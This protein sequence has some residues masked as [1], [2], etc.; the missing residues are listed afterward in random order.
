ME[1]AMSKSVSH[2]QE[3]YEL[4]QVD[5]N[6]TNVANH[7]YG[8]E[9]TKDHIYTVTIIDGVG[10]CTCPDYRYRRAKTGEDCK[11]IA[12]VRENEDCP[13]C[14]GDWPC[15]NCYRSGKDFPK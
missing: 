12:A 8:E 15:F 6:R 1:Q 13:D 9:H 14:I 4:A 5:E 11:H 3:R 10:E 2:S 7:S